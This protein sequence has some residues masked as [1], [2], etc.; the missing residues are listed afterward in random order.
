MIDTKQQLVA[1][2]KNTGQEVY[3]ELFLQKVDRPCI[4]Y[5]EVDN[6]EEDK[7]DTL[8]YSS[9]AYEIKYYSR[10]VEDVGTISAAIDSELDAIGYD[11]Y[12]SYEDREGDYIVKV[13]RYEGLVQEYLN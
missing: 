11:R 12:A 7:G 10:S 1:A 3:Y 9:V 2:L 4:T 5:V 6:Y 8:K 13:L